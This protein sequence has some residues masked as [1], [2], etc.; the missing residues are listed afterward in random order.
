MKTII[1]RLFIVV[2]GSIVMVGCTNKINQTGAW[3]V[4]S[5]STMVP[6]TL[7]SMTDSLKITTS[8]VNLG[9]ATGSSE[10]LSLGSVPWTE[11]DLLLRFYGVDSVYNAQSILSA[12]VVLTRTSYVLQPAGYDVHNMQFVGY[13]MDTVWNPSTF[14][15]D[16]VNA[17]G[18]GT[19][20]VILSQTITDTTV[21]IQVDT[22]FVRQWALAAV[23]PTVKNNGF[24][25]KP[26]NLSGVLSVY[27][28]VS[29]VTGSRPICTIVYVKNGQTDTLTTSSSYSTSVART[30]ISNVAPPGAYRFVQSGTG[31]RENLK[32]DLSRIPN[33]A[34][35]NYAQLTVYADTVDTVYSGNGGDSL[36]AYYVMD[37]STYEINSNN[38]FVCTQAGN[39]YTFNITVPVQQMVNKGN[40][41]F[42]IT[43]FSE[44][45][46]VDTRF[47]YDE[48][49]PDSLKPR[50]TITYTPVVRR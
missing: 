24:I 40:F 46:N 18:R 11:A 13:S 9:L 33:F 45:N 26:L 2:V 22:G 5:D 4:A 27:S 49:A 44:M 1:R 15:W 3:L 32:F 41:G 50:L 6:R 20:N 16:S 21:E 36:T 48:N 28:T 14:T 29:T 25:I 12:K 39:R 8:Q 47:I 30:I 43:R 34:I 23:D 37:P 19:Q 35:V 38:P 42:L 17:I 10:T 7:D 31:L